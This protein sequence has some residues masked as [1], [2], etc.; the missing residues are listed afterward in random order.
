MNVVIVLVDVQRT[1]CSVDIVVQPISGTCQGLGGPG[2]WVAVGIYQVARAIYVDPYEYS[3]S[4]GVLY[5]ALVRLTNRECVGAVLTRV[6]TFA[7]A[8]SSYAPANRCASKLKFL[9][10]LLGE[11]HSVLTLLMTTGTAAV[12]AFVPEYRRGPSVSSWYIR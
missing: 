7:Q 6:P 9:L 4:L 10:S 8:S 5:G 3:S 11:S 2:I 1:P 12:T